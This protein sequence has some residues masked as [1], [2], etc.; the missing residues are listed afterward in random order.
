MSD[1]FSE[2]IVKRK[3]PKNVQIIKILLTVL[4]VVSILIWI[5]PAGI[6]VSAILIFLTWLYYRNND[7]EWEYTLV[8]KSLYV[9]KIMQKAKRKRMA[10]YDLTKMEVVAP[11]ESYHVK[12]Y[13]RRNLRVLDFTSCIPDNKKFALII[14][15]NN[16]LIKVMFEPSERM[17]KEMRDVAPRKV[18]TE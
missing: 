17:L 16:E 4:C 15:H 2:Y 13:D 6:F 18:Y 14:M 9:D 5:V 12:E 10:E 7:V 8:E 3:T 1:Y 11:E